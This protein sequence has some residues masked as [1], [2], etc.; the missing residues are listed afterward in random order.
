MYSY[1]HSVD[2]LFKIYSSIVIRRMYD[3]WKSLVH[4]RTS[5]VWRW[6]ELR[7]PDP[8]E[9][10]ILSLSRLGICH[11]EKYRSTVQ[12]AKLALSI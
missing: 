12:L 6:I 11:H 8:Y 4:K 1:E 5:V 3:P 2:L 7:N 10:L 9:S